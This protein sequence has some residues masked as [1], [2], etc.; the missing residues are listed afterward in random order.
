MIKK[1]VFNISLLFFMFFFSINTYAQSVTLTGNV[2]SAAGDGLYGVSV[3]EVGTKNTTITNKEGG[4][5]IQVASASKLSFSFAGYKTSV[6]DI[7]GQMDIQL[8]LE[9]EDREIDEAIIAYGSQPKTMVTGSMA[10][11]Y[12]DELREVPASN[13][14]QALQGRIAGLQL[15]QTS[16]KPGTSMQMRI[17][18]THSANNTNDPLII[19]DGAPFAGSITDIS[20]DDIK[21]IDVLKDATMTAMYGSRGGNGVILITTNK[22]VKG[23][24]MQLTY[25]GYYGLKSAI[26]YPMMNAAEFIKL[27]A[28]AG[29]SQYGNDESDNVDTDWQGQLYRTGMVNNHDIG[30]SGGTKKGNYKFHVGYYNDKAV[31]PGLD[32]SRFSLRGAFEQEI[33]SY[34]RLGFSTN[35]NFNVNNGEGLEVFNV[36]TMT[37]IADPFVRD[38]EGNI[39]STKRFVNMATDYMPVVTRDIINNLGD[40]WIDKTKGYGSYNSFYGEVKIPGI[41]GLKYAINVGLNHRNS[42]TEKYTGVGVFSVDEHYPAY[43]S[44]GESRIFNQTIDQQLGYDRVFSQKHRLSATLLFSWER[45]KYSSNKYVYSNSTLSSADSSITKS[46]YRSVVG[47]VVY[48]FDNRYMIS[49]TVRSDASLRSAATYYEKTFPSVAMGWD[50]RKASFMKQASSIDALKLRVGYGQ[51]ALTLGSETVITK[52]IGLDFSV[53]KGRLSGA[54]EYYVD[55]SKEV[56]MVLNLPGGTG[57]GIQQID[58]VSIRNQGM[59]LTLKA[60]VLKNMNGWSWDVGVN[61]YTN[62]NKV[63]ALPM[64]QTKDMANCLFVGH[65]LNVIYDYKKTGLWNKTDADYQ[66]MSILE[67]QGNVGMIKVEY[68]GATDETGKPVRAIGEQDRQIIDCDPDFMGGINSRLTYK[69][70]DLV[71]V[72]VF[73]SGGI[74]NSTLYGTDSYLNMNSGRRGQ[75]KTDYWTPDH[76]NAKYPAPGGVA[77]GNQP[78][79]GS[80]TGYF[81]ASY[82]KINTITIGYNVRSELLKTVG[83]STLRLYGT[84]QHPFVFFSPYYNETG[85]DPQTNS[86]ANNGANNVMPSTINRFLVAGANTP[87]TKNFIVGVNVTF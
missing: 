53:F 56:I 58:G 9:E 67:P 62:K 41:K 65:P 21:R 23:K 66:Y 13:I 47:R 86:Y 15:L 34:L 81:N 72:G 1:Q 19:L 27:R 11:I 60:M 79:Y 29:I 52:N 64:G 38:A 8:V 36:L 69:G 54:A 87:S 59:E 30:L 40:Q 45:T 2:R 49:A 75:I 73:Q 44:H 77:N 70:F 6:V 78:K 7:Q 85:L 82:L 32:Y 4:F 48:S 55:N 83:F 22:G 74:L 37:P 28:A 50:I 42:T 20:I 61:L 14:T 57:S 18:G 43:K 12:G 16:T 84:L 76:T 51:R 63:V 24:K 80:T 33:G 35:S 31:V 3:Q 10:T 46:G 5:T 71:V 25:N 39:T 68:T 17:R 26:E